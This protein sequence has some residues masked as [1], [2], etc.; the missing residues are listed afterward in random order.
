M[1]RLGQ[2]ERISNVGFGYCLRTFLDFGLV[3][4]GSRWSVTVHVRL[5]AGQGVAIIK[6][7]K[8]SLG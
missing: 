7:A 8:D 1:R 5:R 6:E 4:T 3:G 2:S